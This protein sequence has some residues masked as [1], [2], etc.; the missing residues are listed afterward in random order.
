M[1]RSSNLAL[2]P[3]DVVVRLRRT[4]GTIGRI[5]SR[6]EWVRVER[7]LTNY[8]VTVQPCDE[9]GHPTGARPY[10]IARRNLARGKP[11]EQ[12]G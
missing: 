9:D 5:V 2:K 4:N 3:G 12:R 7:L 6:E 1:S 8:R 10:K 11:S